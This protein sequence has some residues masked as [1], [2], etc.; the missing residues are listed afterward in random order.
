MWAAIVYV[1]FPSFLAVFLWMDSILLFRV[2]FF[3]QPVRVTIFWMESPKK[4]NYS[5]RTSLFSFRCTR[6]II[7][8]RSLFL[9]SM[10]AQR[11][12]TIFI[13]LFI[14]FFS[15]IFTEFPRHTHGTTTGIVGHWQEMWTFLATVVVAVVKQNEP[16]H[17]CVAIYLFVFCLVRMCEILPPIRFSSKFQTNHTVSNLGLNIAVSHTNQLNLKNLKKNQ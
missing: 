11:V 12:S 9:Y 6:I 14:F 3:L 5:A 4:E 10:F 15:F 7:M 13:R 17:S 16:E 8:W 1:F 2:V